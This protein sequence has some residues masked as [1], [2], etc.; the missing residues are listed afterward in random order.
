MTETTQPRRVRLPARYAGIVMPFVLSIIM[1]FIV[2]GISTLMNVGLRPEFLSLWPAAWG[3]SW[4]VAF[5][6]LLLVTPVAR[7]IV[8]LLVH[9]PSAP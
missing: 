4:L 9:P 6:T 7:R 2:S 5:P 3:L 8:G 1:T